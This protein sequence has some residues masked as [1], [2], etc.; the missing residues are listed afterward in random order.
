VSD[1]PWTEKEIRIISAS[2]STHV[3]TLTISISGSGLHVDEDYPKKS[4][5]FIF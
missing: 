5:S 1:W 2:H 3:S 4:F